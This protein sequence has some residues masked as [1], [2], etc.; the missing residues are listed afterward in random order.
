MVPHFASVGLGGTPW[1][2][3]VSGRSRPGTTYLVGESKSEKGGRKK[4]KKDRLVQEE[5]NRCPSHTIPRKVQQ[6]TCSQ[7][8]AVRYRAHPLCSSPSF[9]LAAAHWTLGA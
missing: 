8:F 9:P 2:A 5:N 7:V 3:C 6:V 4:G 1:L